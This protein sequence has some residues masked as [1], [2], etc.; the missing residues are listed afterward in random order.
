MPV[1]LKHDQRRRQ[2]VLIQLQLGQFRQR[3]LLHLAFHLAAL[4]IQLIQLLRQG[5]G[6]LHV[7]RQQAFNADVHGF[8]APGRIDARAKHK[9]QILR[10]QLRGI[11]GGDVQQGA[12]AGPA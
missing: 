1:R 2:V 4:D 6:A 5:I 7:G 8:H 3:L 10:F 9:A 11:T 12:D